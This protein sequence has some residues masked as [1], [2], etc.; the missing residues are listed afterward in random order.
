VSPE[1]FAVMECVPTCNVVNDNAA[2]LPVGGV[3]TDAGGGVALG[4]E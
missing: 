1:Y 4:N 2:E 3:K